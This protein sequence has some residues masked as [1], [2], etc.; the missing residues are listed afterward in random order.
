MSLSRDKTVDLYGSGN[1][2]FV[3][4]HHVLRD[5]A[6][7]LTN[8]DVPTRRRRL[9]MPKRENRLPKDWERNEGCEFCAQL[10]S[11][12]TGIIFF[13]FLNHWQLLKIC[14]IEGASSRR[15]SCLN[16]FFLFYLR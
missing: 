15:L 14:P 13:S 10:V 8:Q 16:H 9:I 2:L 3:T 7:H 5:L 4:Q 12:H 1:D 11:I 6:I